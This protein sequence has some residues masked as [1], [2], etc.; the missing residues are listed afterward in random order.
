MTDAERNEYFDRKKKEVMER[1]LGKEK[2]YPIPDPITVRLDMS[3]DSLRKNEVNEDPAHRKAMEYLAWYNEEMHRTNGRIV[4]Y[5]E[6]SSLDDEVPP[7][8]K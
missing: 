4:T 1:L 2:K 6:E 8:V 7:P 5:A 3:K